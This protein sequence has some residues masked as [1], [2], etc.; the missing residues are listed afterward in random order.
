MRR[1][2]NKYLL[3]EASVTDPKDDVKLFNRFYR[4]AFLK[5]AHLYREDFC[6][7]FAH[8]VEWIKLHPQNKSYSLDLSKEPLNYG[9]KNHL[10]RLSQEEKKRL[11]IR[12]QNVLHART[13]KVDLITSM[14][15]SYSC[16]KTKAELKKYFQ[17]AFR[18]L[19]KKGMLLIDVMGGSEVQAPNIERTKISL[20]RGKPK[21]TY[22]WEQKNFDAINHEARFAIHFQMA[23]S[24]RKLKN[25]FTYDW[26]LWSL[27]ELQDLMK[28]VGFDDVHIYWEGTRRNSEEGNGVFTRKKSVADCEVWIAYIA[29]IKA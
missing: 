9:I 3:Y 16:L 19:H 2:L 7:T 5:D 14:N 17:N 27:P 6:G 23:D 11:S 12:R 26:R 13:P 8:S 21:F 4:L 25:V 15:F 18:S 29:G 1:A 24:K 10:I 22:I 20:G 28:E